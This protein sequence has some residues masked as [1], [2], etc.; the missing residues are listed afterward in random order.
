VVIAPIT[1]G[2][3]FSAS[4]NGAMLAYT[5]TANA[6]IL[7]S[8]SVVPIEGGEPE[9]VNE[10]GVVAFEWSPSGEQLLF[11]TVNAEGTA[12]IPQIWEAGSVEMYEELLPTQEMISSYLPFWDQYSRVLTLWAPDGASF[13]LPVDGENGG[14]IVVY[15]VASGDTTRVSG[16][17]FA[18][19]APAS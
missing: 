2:T 14:S 15:D 19:W 8:L 6:P 18:S 12:L 3:F 13:V 1:G 11:M 16:G 17:R 9:S 10:D 5:D 4:A 7:G